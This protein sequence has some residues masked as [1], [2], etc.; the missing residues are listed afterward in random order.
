MNK[1]HLTIAFLLKLGVKDVPTRF[2]F[3]SNDKA[4][5]N[6]KRRV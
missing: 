4:D 3:T 6:V 1:W 5:E 2:R